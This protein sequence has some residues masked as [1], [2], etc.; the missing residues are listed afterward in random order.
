MNKTVNTIALS[1]IL[2]FSSG[3]QSVSAA[4]YTT[5]MNSIYSTLSVQIFSDL[6]THGRIDHRDLN[7][8]NILALKV[9]RQDSIEYLSGGK[10]GRALDESYH[11]A[12]ENFS[13]ENYLDL[14]QWA[15]V[16]IAQTA[17]LY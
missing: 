7:E 8:E 11:A 15:G 17:D 6:S 2:T 12:T 4:V 3:P 13:E 10:V 9:L 5:M 16:I 14:N 1:L